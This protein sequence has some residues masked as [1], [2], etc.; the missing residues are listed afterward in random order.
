[1]PRYA[2]GSVLKRGS[3]PVQTKPAGVETASTTS[4]VLEVG[5]AAVAHVEVGVTAVSGTSPTMSIVVEGSSDLVNWYT[6]ATIGANGYSVGSVATAPS[7]ITAAGTYRALVPLGQF[8]RSRSVIGG[9]TPS[10]NYAVN[11]EPS[12]GPLG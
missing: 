4:G 2:S 10:F 1:M 8:I 11:V 9:T 3:G 12:E 5:Q 7:A 6:L